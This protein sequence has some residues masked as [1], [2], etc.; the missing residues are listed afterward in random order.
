MFIGKCVTERGREIQEQT[1]K[2]YEEL[3]INKP[4]LGSLLS[5]KCIL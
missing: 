5:I 2:S 1:K 4:S 3:K